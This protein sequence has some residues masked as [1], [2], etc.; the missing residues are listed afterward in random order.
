METG[1]K[2]CRALCD[3]LRMCGIHNWKKKKKN[4]KKADELSEHPRGP[5]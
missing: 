1:L 3:W 4:H 5:G 2:C